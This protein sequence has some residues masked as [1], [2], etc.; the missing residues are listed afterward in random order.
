M[1]ADKYQD[2][3]IKDGRFI[4]RFEEMYQQFADPWCLADAMRTSYRKWDS[5]I[6]MRHFGIQSIVEFGCGLGFYTSILAQEGFRVIGIDVSQT[7]IAKAQARFPELSFRCDV[8][9]NLARYND[10]DAVLFADITWYIL[11]ELD[12][13]FAE[14][15]RAWSGKLF[16]HN[17]VFYKGQAQRYGREYFTTIDEFIARV[18]FPLVARAEA[19]AEDLDGI[20]TSTAFRIG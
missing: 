17:L 6:T 2:L 12:D 13:L 7:A 15:R 5:V 20:E 16:V 18:P 4:G 11:P 3:V 10:Y 1:S 19:T 9:A 8:V 14:M